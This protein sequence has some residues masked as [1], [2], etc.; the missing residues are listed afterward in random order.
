MPNSLYVPFLTT[1]TVAR[2]AIPPDTINIRTFYVPGPLCAPDAL[3]FPF[4]KEANIRPANSVSNGVIFTQGQ[5][6]FSAVDSS[7]QSVLELDNGQLIVVSQLGDAGSYYLDPNG[8]GELFY[9]CPG[10]V[11][12]DKPKDYMPVPNVNFALSQ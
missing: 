9:D 11:N 4:V 8:S 3:I 5:L 12:T 7:L 1:V 10:E 2:P 6:G